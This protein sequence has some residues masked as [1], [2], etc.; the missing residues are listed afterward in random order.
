MENVEPKHPNSKNEI[1]QRNRIMKEEKSE[2]EKI[3]VR[4]KLSLIR[5]YKAQAYPPQGPRLTADDLVTN[6]PYTKNSFTTPRA[7]LVKKL[8]SMNIMGKNKSLSLL[9]DIWK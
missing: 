6:H 7:V 3:K 1:R 5:L 9:I 2:M 4:M 8:H